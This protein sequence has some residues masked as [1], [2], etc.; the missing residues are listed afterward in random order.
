M[1]TYF[2]IP[3]NRLHKIKD[4]QKLNIS[5]II[6]DLEDSIKVS[7]RKQVLE[8]LLV[9]NDFK[10]FY[11]RIPLYSS[12][13]N[14]ETYFFVELYKNGFRKFVFPKIQN[15]SDF[16][17][18]ISE[19]TFNDIQIIL[20]I[21]NSRFFLEVKEV[22]LEYRN[23]FSGIGIGSHDFM[24]ELGGVH[25]LKNLEFI[26]QQ[27][28][29]LAR[30]I[31]IKAIDIASMEITNSSI[32]KEEIL[33]GVHKGYDAKFFIHP[34]QINIFKAISL[35]SQNEIRWALMVKNEFNKVTSEE[36]FNPVIVEGR[37][38]ERPHLNKAI[39]IIKYYES[40]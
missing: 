20:L 23:V 5:H 34:W 40:K 21:E 30:M 14:L 13:E 10:D 15:Y 6:I 22:L 33:D 32:L 37:V 25:D 7:E 11:I 4:I 29:C 39:K 35:Y 16:K 38:V 3:G 12:Q 18:I 19:D 17:T 9:S 24:A 8:K 36:E 31:K 28:L 27:L 1:E 2:F 26:R